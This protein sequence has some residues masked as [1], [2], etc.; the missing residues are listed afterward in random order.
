MRGR[1][2]RAPRRREQP[3]R[4]PGVRWGG[5]SVPRF[6]SD[7]ADTVTAERDASLTGQ[8]GREFAATPLGMDR[9]MLEGVFIDQTMEVLF[10]FAGHF[11][12]SSRARAVDEA[13]DTLA[14]EA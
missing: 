4:E 5:R 9:A 1:R 7:P 6:F 8:H 3:G 14:R 12:R 13:L 11:R 10:Q 2:V